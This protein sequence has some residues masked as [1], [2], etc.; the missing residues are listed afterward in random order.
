M[1][2]YVYKSRRKSDTYIYLR[3]READLVA[4]RANPEYQQAMAG[5]AETYSEPQSVGVW[6][7]VDL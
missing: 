7:V 6:D 4:A 1:Q 3:E 2:A 5:L